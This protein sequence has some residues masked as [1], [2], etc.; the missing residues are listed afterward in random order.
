MLRRL[1]PAPTNADYRGHPAAPWLLGI[2]LVLKF[3]PAVAAVGNGR[4]AAGVADGIPLETFT[5]AGASAVVALFG[6]MG[7]TQALLAAVGGLVLW[8]YRTALPGLTLFFLVE[9]L[10]R[11]LVAWYAPLPRAPGNAGSTLGWVGLA[12]LLVTLGLSLRTQGRD[13][14]PSPG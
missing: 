11:K 9:F 6:A 8:R 4:Y 1:I 13:D 3:I 10:A 14:P 7:V 5:P 12:L 2:V